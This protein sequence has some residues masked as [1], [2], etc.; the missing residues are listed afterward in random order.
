MRVQWIRLEDNMLVDW[1]SCN[2]LSTFHHENPHMDM[3][4]TPCPHPLAPPVVS[5]GHGGPWSPSGAHPH[6]TTSLEVLQARVLK[7]VYV[8]GPQVPDMYVLTLSHPK[9]HTLDLF[10]DACIYE[11]KEFKWDVDSLVAFLT[12]FGSHVLH[13]S[14]FER[15]LENDQG[16]VWKAGINAAM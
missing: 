5:Q 11:W 14:N 8:I 2:Q 6:P 7:V 16:S 9:L 12:F 13:S 4:P 3:E 15:S 1:I 10:C